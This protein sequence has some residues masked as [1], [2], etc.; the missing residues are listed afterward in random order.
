MGEAKH[1]GDYYERCTRSNSYNSGTATPDT[2]CAD[3][4]TRNTT[5]GQRY[6]SAARMTGR[7]VAQHAKSDIPMSWWHFFSVGWQ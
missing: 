5:P 2:I 4:A 1:D 3:V 7:R 6:T